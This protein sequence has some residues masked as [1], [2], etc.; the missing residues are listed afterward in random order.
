MLGV[1]DKSWLVEM[2][3]SIENDTPA[4]DEPQSQ[5]AADAP[6]SAYFGLGHGIKFYQLP[7]VF[8]VSLAGMAL[9][10]YLLKG[11]SHDELCGKLLDV[12][13]GSGALA[14]LMRSMGA[15]DISATD[16]SNDAVVL[17]K[18]NE[19]L[20]FSDRKIQFFSGDLFEGLPAREPY[21]TIIFNPPG[22]RTPSDRLLEQLRRNANA[23]E[24]APEAMFY[25]DRVL[26]RF[27]AELPTRLHQKGRALIGLNSLVGIQDVLARYRAARSSRPLK[28]RLLERHSLP[29]LFYS[30]G[31][32]QAEPYLR[33]EFRDWQNRWGAAY[34]IDSQGRLY[35]SY[36]VVE[37]TRFR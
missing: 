37:C 19:L 35:W 4:S 17:A 10:A 28:F 22:W 26:L 21:D 23:S 29:L 12:G 1:S 34:T 6:Y 9:G 16:V 31:W 14:L 5:A 13:T 8:K 3:C 20:N 18:Q 24:M 36:E 11:L 15:C 7:G 2:L 25:G 27:L 32:K 30:N 33:E